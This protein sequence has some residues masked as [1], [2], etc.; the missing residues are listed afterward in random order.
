M[1]TVIMATTGHEMLTVAPKSCVKMTVPQTVLIIANTDN[2]LWKQ[3]P[4]LK[5]FCKI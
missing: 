4:F 1:S 3:Q 5:A 2:S